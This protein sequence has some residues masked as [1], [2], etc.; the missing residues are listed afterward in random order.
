MDTPPFVPWSEGG[1]GV[2]VFTTGLDITGLDSAALLFV[3]RL[4]ACT[5]VLSAAC[6]AAL[7][8]IRSEGR[9]VVSLLMFVAP[10]TSTAPCKVGTT[11]WE[12]A[13]INPS[14]PPFP[15]RSV[16]GIGVLIFTAAAGPA[17]TTFDS[18]ASDKIGI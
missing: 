6:L 2:F 5:V 9:T 17:A 15:T 4:E 10:D 18:A 1:I 7:P 14:A 12:T 13:G 3:T 11:G 8:L 16:G